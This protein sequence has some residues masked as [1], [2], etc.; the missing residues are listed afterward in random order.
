[1]IRVPPKRLNSTMPSGRA[2]RDRVD[3]DLERL[4]ARRAL[5]RQQDPSVCEPSESSRIVSDALRSARRSR[6]RRRPPARP[7][8]RARSRP[9]SRCRAADRG[10]RSRRSRAAGRRS[11]APRPRRSRRRRRRRP[12]NRSGQ[13]LQ[14]S[15]HDRC[16]ASSRVG[17]TSS[18]CIEPETSITSTI[19]ASSRSASRV[20]LGR[21]KPT[22]SV[23]RASRK[24]ARPAWRRHERVLD[25]AREHVE[26][27]VADG[28]LARPPLSRR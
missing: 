26:V 6:P 5:L 12:W 8:P 20:T 15:A 13:A 17:S 24:S 2:E 21:A 7:R 3:R 27:R 10:S 25:D 22:S 28:V 23:A 14:E 1:M 16:A 11:R 19:V 4:R 18:A 9:R